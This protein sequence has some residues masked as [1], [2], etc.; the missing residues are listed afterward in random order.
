MSSAVITHQFF[1]ADWA[2]DI[3]I[4]GV[5]C[6]IVG[7]FRYILDSHPQGTYLLVRV[8][9]GPHRTLVG[10]ANAASVNRE[11]ISQYEPKITVVYTYGSPGHGTAGR[12]DAYLL[13]G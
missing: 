10:T 12:V 1:L 4:G 3:A 2:A 13:R 6:R 11:T 5:N 7:L 8:I 9:S